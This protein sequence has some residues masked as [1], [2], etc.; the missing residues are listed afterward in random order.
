M[1]QGGPRTPHATVHTRAHT[2]G[3]AAIERRIS[4]NRFRAGHHA[5]VAGLGRAYRAVG[6]AHAGALRCAGFGARG[7]WGNRRG[8]VKS[9]KYVGPPARVVEGGL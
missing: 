8:R 3:D 1:K 9:S 6:R 5:G 7:A 4:G 2:N